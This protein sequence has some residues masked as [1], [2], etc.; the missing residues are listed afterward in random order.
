[1]LRWLA[2]LA[3]ALWLLQAGAQDLKPVPPLQARVT[4][5]IGMLTQAQRRRIYDN[6]RIEFEL[7]GFDP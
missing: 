3:L 5:T 4:D 7:L 6:A 1:M 2:G